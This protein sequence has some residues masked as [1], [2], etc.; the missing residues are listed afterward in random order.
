MQRTVF[1]SYVEVH[2]VGDLQSVLSEAQAR[3]EQEDP[4]AVVRVNLHRVNLIRETLSDGSAVYDLRFYH[5][6]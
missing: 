3:A 4:S 6:A 5:D 1:D 2:D